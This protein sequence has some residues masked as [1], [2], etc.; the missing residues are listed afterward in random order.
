M[1]VKLSQLVVVLCVVTALSITL[2]YLS[3]QTDVHQL[4]AIQ[5]QL[6]RFHDDD[7]GNHLA[8][9]ATEQRPEETTTREASKQMV[10]P[11]EDSVPRDRVL[12]IGE[13]PRLIFQDLRRRRTVFV[14]VVTAKRY[15]L[16]RAKAI[17]ET[18]GQDVAKL[19]FFSSSDT[20]NGGLPVVNLPDVDDTYPPQ[21]K[22]FRMLKYM[23]DNFIDQF[24]WF[25]RADD[26]VYVRG[27]KLV[28]FL[29]GIDSSQPIYMGQPGFGRI[30]D[31]KRLQ[32]HDG[33]VYCMGGTG[34]LF[35][36]ALL[37]RLAPWI[38]DCLAHTIVSWNEDVE[39]GR[40]VS[41]RAGQQ[42][43]WSYDLD[44]YFFNDY[45][46][47]MFADSQFQDLRR[48]HYATRAITLH[49]VK[50]PDM[51]RSLHKLFKESD[52]NALR[53]Q[54]NRVRAKLMDLSKNK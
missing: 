54:E 36:R 29:D 23:H 41:R 33:E 13:R 53:E 48:H 38:E 26:D 37:K 27:Q 25:M 35:S 39:V 12:R 22:V 1:R 47:K 40:C 24:D 50:N 18:W 4:E 11:R 8:Q 5:S 32:L 20:H 3:P 46:N 28:S 6:H 10:K 19:S 45:S 52:L 7:K 30:E 31:R 2:L 42:C 17:H 15:L 51:M 16:T 14:G 34:V 43:T 21:K 9:A 49:P 44:R